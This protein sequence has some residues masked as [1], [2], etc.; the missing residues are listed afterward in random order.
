ME[1][2]A[3]FTSYIMEVSAPEFSVLHRTEIGSATSPGS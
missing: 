3:S 2:F 1:V